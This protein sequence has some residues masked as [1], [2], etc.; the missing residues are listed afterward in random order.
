[1]LKSN[2][3]LRVVFFTLKSWI[4]PSSTVY[5]TC[6]GLTTS[7]KMRTMAAMAMIKTRAVIAMHLRTLDRVV[8][9]AGLA[10]VVFGKVE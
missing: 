5:V 9:I 10:M 6:A 2:V 3:A 7:H 4:E 1:M 8:R